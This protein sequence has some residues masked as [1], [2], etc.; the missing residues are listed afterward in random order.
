MG[1]QFYS[2]NMRKPN[3]LIV[4]FSVFIIVSCGEFLGFSD[5]P[6]LDLGSIKKIYLYI[7]TESMD[8]LYESVSETDFVPCIY[9]TGNTRQ[10]ALIRVRGFTSRIDP[11]KSFTLKYENNDGILIK[12]ALETAYDSFVTNRIAMHAYWL[13]GLPLGLQATYTYP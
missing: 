8:K 10:E 1:N 11:K 3:F 2:K 12:Y 4:V 5:P 7:T 13:L 9:Q 6:E